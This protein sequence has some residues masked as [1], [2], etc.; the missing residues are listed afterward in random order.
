MNTRPP[1]SIVANTFIPFALML[2]AGNLLAEMS[3]NLI[4]AR[5]DYSLWIT[6]A[7]ALPSL[8]MAALYDLRR[9]PIGV[10]NCWRLLWTFGLVSYLLHVYFL[11]SEYFE[12]NFADFIN[13]QSPLVAYVTFG[14][15][16]LWTIEVCLLW[17]GARSSTGFYRYQILTHFVA[18]ATLALMT[19]VLGSGLVWWAGVVTA[20]LV[21][22]ALLSRL[23][24]G[25]ESS[26]VTSE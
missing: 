9:E 25:R 18:M 26:Q 23:L 10:F 8:L 13:Q 11:F 16:I 15:M 20:A 4:L 14:L 22:S 1:F 12:R 2:V 17:S 24:F 7:M 6:F 5:V 19:I 3:Q 21:G